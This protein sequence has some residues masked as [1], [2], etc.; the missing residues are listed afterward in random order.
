MDPKELTA[1]L[2]ASLEEARKGATKGGLAAELVKVLKEAEEKPADK[3]RG[4][5][6]VSASFVD[7]LAR[8]ISAYKKK[9]EEAKKEGE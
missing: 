2:E 7:L 8:K 9:K 1:A 3:P 4:T 6:E 5:D